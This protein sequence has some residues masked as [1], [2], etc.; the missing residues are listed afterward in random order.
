[1]VIFIHKYIF[2]DKF[3]SDRP[4][5]LGRPQEHVERAERERAPGASGEARVVIFFGECGHRGGCGSSWTDGAPGALAT[6]MAVTTQVR[7]G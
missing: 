6:R 2:P 7:G 5:I 3:Y 1:M 4:P